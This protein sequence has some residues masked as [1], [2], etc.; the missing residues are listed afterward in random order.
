MWHSLTVHFQMM[1]VFANSV[2]NAKHMTV[3]TFVAEESVCTDVY[4]RSLDSAHQA[5]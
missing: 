5:Q 4:T 3:C 1:V 2:H